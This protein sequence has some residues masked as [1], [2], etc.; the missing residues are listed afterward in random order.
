MF[1]SL[2]ELVVRLCC[3]AGAMDWFIKVERTSDGQLYL[4]CGRWGTRRPGDRSA[5]Q[6]AVGDGRRR[7]RLDSQLLTSDDVDERVLDQRRED[8]HEADDHPD[9]DRFDVGHSRQRLASGA[10]HR[11][12]RQHGQQAERDARR[13]RVDVDPERHPRQ[14]HDQDRRHVDLNEEVTDVAAQHETQREAGES[15]W[16]DTT[17][18]TYYWHITKVKASHTRY[19]ALGPKRGSGDLASSGVQRHSTWSGVRRRSRP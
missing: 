9:V 6:R 4:Q 13:T 11:R 2:Q 10:A 8:E 7:R 5:S 16:H 18:T 1:N 12:R 14:D 15:T 17:S 3:F 19:W